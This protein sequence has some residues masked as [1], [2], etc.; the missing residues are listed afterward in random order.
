MVGDQDSDLACG[1]A[2]GCKVAL[3]E[4]PG[5][6]HKRGKVEPDLRVRDLGEL[7]DGVFGVR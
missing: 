5:S 3:L 7:A 4:H 2:A 1:R 6:E